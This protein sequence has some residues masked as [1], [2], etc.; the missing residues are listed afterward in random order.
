MSTLPQSR[1]FYAHSGVLDYEEERKTFHIEVP[2][3]FNF[4]DDVIDK[5]AE[6]E[7]VSKILLSILRLWLFPLLHNTIGDK[8]ENL[9]QILTANSVNFISQSLCLGLAVCLLV[10]FELK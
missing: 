7:K 1:A 5:W 9:M 6:R 10:T 2:E 3:Y 4:C 8:N